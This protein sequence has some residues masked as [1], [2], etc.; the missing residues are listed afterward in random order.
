MTGVLNVETAPEGAKIF[1]DGKDTLLISTATFILPA[2]VHDYIVSLNG[3]ISI[4]GQVIVYEGQYTYLVV[5]LESESYV[6]YKKLITISA[7]GIGLT[8]LAI[9]LKRH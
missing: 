2:G 4:K 3:Y 7:I 6:L 1:L 9:I 5:T 8:A